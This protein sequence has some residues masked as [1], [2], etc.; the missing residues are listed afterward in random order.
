M[1]GSHLNCAARVEGRSLDRRPEQTSHC[2]GADLETS[3]QRTDSL[4]IVIVSHNSRA[5]LERCVASILQFSSHL[6]PEMIV[7]DNGSSDDTPT[8]LERIDGVTVLRNPSNRGAG[9]ARNQGMRLARS[10][11]LLLMDCDAY[12]TDDVIGR[13]VAEMVASP[14]VS[15]LAPEL[16]FPGGRR[17]YNAYRAMSIRCTLVRDLWLYKVL[18]REMRARTL[19]GG[20]YDGFEDAQPDWLAAPFIMLRRDVFVQC[21][22]FDEQLFPEDSEWGIRVSR[23]GRRMLYAPRL[24]AVVHTGS[25]GAGDSGAVLRMHHR[26]GLRAYRKLNGRMLSIGYWS[27]ELFGAAVRMTAYRVA[28]LVEPGSVFYA[29]QVMHYRQLC[30]VYLDIGLGR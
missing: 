29:A 14:G 5:D 17:Q 30:R 4:S 12:V 15:V 20:Y 28:S 24:G 25:T 22:G 1:S 3:T 21:G 19:L 10:E 23:A 26:A 16:R 9:A 8:S 6:R 18:P 27:A 2:D 7:V 11:L 13:A